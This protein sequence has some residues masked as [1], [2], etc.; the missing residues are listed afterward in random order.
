MP[1]GADKLARVHVFFPSCR[2]KSCSALAAPG[3]E[4][5][6]VLKKNGRHAAAK[7]ETMSLT[8]VV[9]SNA[10]RSLDAKSS[11][12]QRQLNVESDMDRYT[13]LEG[14]PNEDIPIHQALWSRPRSS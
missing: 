2:K 12:T 10:Q 7:P 14:K 3:Q 8:A 5:I 13:H 11:L 1:V 6:V 4:Q 9:E